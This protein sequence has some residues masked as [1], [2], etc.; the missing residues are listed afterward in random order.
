M[1]LAI[2]QPYF[3]PY[4]G[5]FQLIGSV[6]VFVI[7]DNIKYTKKGWIN[8]N[9]ILQNG[10]DVV[11]SL[12]LKHDSDYLDICK[13]ELALDFKPK[14]LLNQ[15]SGAYRKAPYFEQTYA[16]VE[17]VFAQKEKNLFEFLHCSIIEI[18]K[19]LGITTPLIVS[20]SIIIDHTLKS[21]EK[22]LALC[23]A[24]GAATYVNAIG[25]KDLYSKNVFKENNIELQFIQSN[26]FDYPQFSNNFI[27]SLSIIDVM[28]FNSI[29]KIQTF[30]LTNY[31]LI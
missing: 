30:F 16:L 5:Y 7:Y 9:R 21:Q 3:F 6:D 14:K 19:H 17:R 25:G 8:R 13:R 2:M 23:A 18:C 26:P 15:F 20:S 28:M 27:P 29:E 11:F 4:I 22:V 12:M 10:S 24:V 31:E 1:K